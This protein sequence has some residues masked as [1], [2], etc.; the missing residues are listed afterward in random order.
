MKKK[1]PTT[2]S[3]PAASVKLSKLPIPPVIVMA[4]LTASALLL[5]AC[6][7]SS[8]HTS[9]ASATPAV[10]TQET[11][12]ADY[13]EQGA[14]ISRNGT[15]TEASEISDSGAMSSGNYKAESPSVKT[16]RKLIR[17]V[18]MDVETNDFDSLLTGINNKI[19]A[20][21]GYTEQSNISGRRAGY[22]NQPYPRS[23]YITARIPADKLDIF[24]S[25]V[26]DTGN[27]INKS[28]ST[29]D[30]TLRYSDIES[31]KKSL[32]VEQ[33]RL[34]A[35]LEKA[36]TLEAVIALEQRLSDI[37]YELESMESQLK[38]YDNQVDYST[39][40][41]NI[42]EV[43]QYTPTAPETVTQRINRGFANT[44][45]SMSRF[46]VNLFVLLVS[47]SPVWI[48]AAVIAVVVILWLRR[49][50]KLRKNAV[51]TP[52]SAAARPENTV[53]KPNDGDGKS[54][55][56]AAKPDDMQKL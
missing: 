34:W 1:S 32:T 52:K 48:P 4:V 43:I 23:A 41:L 55:D 29:D 8:A 37:R 3:G 18:N 45:D 42:N 20:L 49:R 11:A 2:A 22:Q 17:N 56:T 9:P 14:G 54:D 16:G 13:Y 15:A 26:E 21:G 39:V 28:E 44:T 53:V 47:L 51:V 31:R 36:D 6:G 33:D 10:Y 38:L 7:S 46:F 35:L 12:A 25:S 40:T 5:S 50:R 30:V 27:V 24:V 19:A